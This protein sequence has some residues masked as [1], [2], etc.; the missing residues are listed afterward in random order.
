MEIKGSPAPRRVRVLSVSPGERRRCSPVRSTLRALSR[1]WPSPSSRS[2]VCDSDG[3]F[4]GFLRAFLWKG[5][6]PGAELSEHGLSST[7]TF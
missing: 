2:R 3:A 6:L 1:A 5:S 4:H 7:A